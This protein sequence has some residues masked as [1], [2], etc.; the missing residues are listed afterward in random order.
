M[1]KEGMLKY[2]ENTKPG[3][4]EWQRIINQEDESLV[5]DKTYFENS[6]IHETGLIIMYE[7]VNKHHLEKK[8]SLLNFYFALPVSEILYIC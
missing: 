1:E 2:V 4:V 6:L 7:R 3:D 5:K 8:R